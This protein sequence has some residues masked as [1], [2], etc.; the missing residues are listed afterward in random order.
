[1]VF[2]VLANAYYCGVLTMF[3]TYPVSQLFENEMQAMRAFPEW[4][5]LFL[6]G[7]EA[8]IFQFATQGFNDYVAYWNR[9]KENPTQFTFGSMEE[10]L[11]L[12]DGGQNIMMV[13]TGQFFAHLKEKPTTHEIYVFGQHA[14]EFRCLILHMNSPLLPMFEQGVSHFREKGVQQTLFSKWFGKGVRNELKFGGNI[15]TIG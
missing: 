11:E 6:E 7:W 5:L 4:R 8:N 9:Y 1:M 2:F 10:G 14:F 12:I 3:F 15:L 13:N